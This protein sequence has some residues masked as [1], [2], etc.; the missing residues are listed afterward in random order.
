LLEHGREL[1]PR[2]V[3]AL[4]QRLDFVA[5]IEALAGQ[6]LKGRSKQRAFLR[7]GRA[8]DKKALSRNICGGMRPIKLPSHGVQSLSVI[9]HRL[10]VPVA[11]PRQ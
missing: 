4:G 8:L 3:S 6:D 1:P 5:N 11:A 10:A 2:N 9:L 7:A